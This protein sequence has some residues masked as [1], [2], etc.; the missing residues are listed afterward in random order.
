MGFTITVYDSVEP[1]ITTSSKLPDGYNGED[2]EVKLAADGG[3]E[4]SWTL[5]DGLLPAGLS[6]DQY[7]GVIAGNIQSNAKTFKFTVC[8]SNDFG[9]KTKT[10]SLKVK[11]GTPSF[12]TD[13]NLKNGTWQK[14]Y[15]ETIKLTNF[16]ATTWMLVGDLPDG[17]TF[18]KGK[19]SGKPQECGDF[20]L[21]VI[22]SNGS[23]ELT[24]DFNLTIEGITPKISGSFKKGNEN[25]YYTSTLKAKG[26]TP[27]TWTFG[28]LPEGLEATPSE[29]GEECVISGIPKETFNSKIKVTVTNGSGDED[30][31]VSKGIKMTIKAVRPIFKTKITDLTTWTVNERRTFQFEL[32]KSPAKVDWS[33]SGNFPAGLD[34]EP[35]TGLLQGAP[36]QVGTY[37]FSVIA[38]NASKP[39]YKKSL[40]V[41]LDVVAP[42]T[43][44]PA[45][46]GEEEETIEDEAP[47]F[48]DGVAYHERGELTTEMLARIANSDEV[49]AAVLPAI[50]VEEEGMYDFTVSLDLSVPEGG[51][52]VW[53]SFPDG[54]DDENDAENAI[55]LDDEGNTVEVVPETYSVTV[56][57]WLE[58][59]VIYEPVI[60]VKI[61]E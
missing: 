61:K 58:P 35:D 42:Q 13:P 30:T 28:D 21:T 33:T 6:L 7:S 55:F 3:D 53:H 22:A 4:L 46:D 11:S 52:L 23:V 18:S 34:L 17:L 8:A 25:E 41:I 38:K 26:T 54:V 39:S 59:G 60:A 16:K 12:K 48:V 50:E 29:T 14:K 43:P 31:S 32:S 37:R 15:T 36:T 40:N 1:T 44:A 45:T 20:E 51:R 10:F 5:K 2:Y 9:S 24:Q 47:E 57:A 27:M 49:I 56:S 19:I